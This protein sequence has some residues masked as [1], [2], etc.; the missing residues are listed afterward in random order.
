[1]AAFAL[2]V[3]SGWWLLVPASLAAQDPALLKI[4]ATGEARQKL[5]CRIHLRDHNRKPV[6]VS[7][8]PF[9]HD[10]F[11]T[12]GQIELTLPAGKYFWEIE[13]G[14]EF[15]RKKGTLELKRGKTTQLAVAIRRIAHL[16]ERGWFS[17]DLHV[18]RSPKNIELLMRAEDLDFAPVITWWNRPAKKTKAAPETVFQFDGH[19]L[20][21]RMAGED[22]REGGALLF[23]G[24]N[25]P[26]DLT[27]KSREFPSPMH[28]VRQAREI[29]PKV[30]I[31]MEKP[32]WWD[33]PV[34]L[35]SGKMNSIGLANNH[36]CR[37]QMLASEAWGKPRNK[38]RWP[39]PTGNGYWTQEIYYHI[40]NSGIRIPPSAGS[41]S[42]V[43]PN[44]VGYNRVYVQC[45]DGFTRD[46]WFANLSQGKCFVTNGP[47]LLG[48]ANGQVPGHTLKV[49]GERGTKIELE[50]ELVSLDHVPQLEVVYN[51]QVIKSISCQKKRSQKLTTTLE[52]GK[53][54][55]LLVRAITD[56]KNTF[57]FASTAPWYIEDQNATTNISKASVSFFERWVLERIKRVKA[58]VTDATEQSLILKHHLQA[59]EYWQQRL[60]A[61]TCE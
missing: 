51:G 59:V 50:I 53:A 14:P 16:R 41:A 48:R 60:K 32:F 6:K 35:A 19:R 42:G 34:W 52:I 47:L 38:T 56:Q 5:P 28:F 7:A 61:A 21:T 26:L 17:G 31:D 45:Q 2:L 30:W 43:L 55:W 10:H 33:V 13:K 37:S 40:L 24:L 8:V 39:D 4:A 3:C 29:N 23:F 18:H 1:M 22:E 44:P 27:V 12:E 46:Q 9:W 11:V 36:M 25:R 54:G 15:E 49:G 57:R 58:N 20:Y